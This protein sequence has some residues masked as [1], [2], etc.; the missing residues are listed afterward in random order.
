MESVITKAESHS[1]VIQHEWSVIRPEL[2]FDAV[3]IANELIKMLEGINK[4]KTNL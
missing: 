1:S 4:Y 3:N 2:D